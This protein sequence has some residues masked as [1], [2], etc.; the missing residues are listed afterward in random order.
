MKNSDMDNTA[1]GTTMSGRQKKKQKRGGSAAPPSPSADADPTKLD[2]KANVL[3]R[4]LTNA[5]QEVAS[6]LSVVSKE[7]QTPIF[8]RLMKHPS[9]LF[10]QEFTVALR[11]QAVVK[12]CNEQD[13]NNVLRSVPSLRKFKLHCKGDKECENTNEFN[14]YQAQLTV[15]K[16][17]FIKGANELV[18]KTLKLQ[19]RK[20]SNGILRQMCDIIH[21]I[22]QW[23]SQKGGIPNYTPERLAMDLFAYHNERITKMLSVVN[24]TMADVINSYLKML[25]EERPNAPMPQS[26][27]FPNFVTDTLNPPQIIHDPYNDRQVTLGTAGTPRLHDGDATASEGVNNNNGDNTVDASDAAAVDTANADKSAETEDPQI[28]HE[29]NLTGQG[30]NEDMFLEKDQQLTQENAVTNTG[31]DGA[32]FSSEDDDSSSPSD[33]EN[34]LRERDFEFSQKHLD[35]VKED[36]NYADEMNSVDSILLGNCW[37][38]FGPDLSFINQPHQRILMYCT[39]H[40]N[41]FL[42]RPW[43]AFMSMKEQTLGELELA[44]QWTFKSHK[45]TA[46]S[47]ISLINKEAKATRPILKKTIRDVQTEVES[48][49]KEDIGNLKHDVRLLKQSKKQRQ[50]EKQRQRKRKAVEFAADDDDDDASHNEHI[51]IEDDADSEEEA[52]ESADVEKKKKN[53]VCKFFLKGRCNRGD[54][55]LYLHEAKSPKGPGGRSPKTTPTLNNQINSAGQGSKGTGKGSGKKSTKKLKKQP[56]STMRN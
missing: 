2:E 20:H 27:V 49:T 48:E 34:V 33:D 35:G 39:L 6:T 12:K 37:E 46:E 18:L 24:I 29:D 13:S 5:N 1:S 8:F 25:R 53:I 42:Y 26:S 44:R 17:D 40:F 55:C 38:K 31:R 23:N 9:L 32:T 10:F 43:N 19:E 15:L 50:L 14:E 16:N 52:S 54:N 36:D 21:K 51:M 56:K 7:L 45:N 30:D 11:H 3:D 4:A 41:M 47:A 22:S 28:T